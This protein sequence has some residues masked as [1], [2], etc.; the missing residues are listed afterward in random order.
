VLPLRLR[1]GRVEEVKLRV[2]VPF[3]VIPGTQFT[4]QD[5]PLEA[6]D[7]IVLLTDG[8]LERNAATLDVAAALAASADLH[9]RELVHELG[10]AVLHATGGDLRDDATMV[11][12]DWYG[13]PRRAR[14]VEQG[15]D[16]SRA[17]AAR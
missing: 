5:F 3:G 14:T 13:G 8:M 10:S 1:H 16:L 6:G 17:S 15:A 9:P 2:E 11:C 7:R 4:V 12:L